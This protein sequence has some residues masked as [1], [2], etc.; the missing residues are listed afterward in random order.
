M[1]APTD[2]RCLLQFLFL[3]PLVQN[4]YAW[5]LVGASELDLVCVCVFI[6]GMNTFAIKFKGL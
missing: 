5:R 3:T 4:N 2:I 1:P 6:Q